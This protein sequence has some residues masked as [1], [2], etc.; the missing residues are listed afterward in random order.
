MEHFSDDLVDRLEDLPHNQS[1][2]RKYHC[3][4][5]IREW[6][7]A[8]TW[9]RGHVGQTYDE[10]LPKWI[11]LKWLPTE[12]RNAKGLE[13]TTTLTVRCSDGSIREA[14][15]PNSP[16]VRENSNNLFFH[17]ENHKLCRPLPRREAMAVWN[18]RAKKN[19]TMTY[20]EWWQNRRTYRVIGKS[21]R[22]LLED[23]IWYLLSYPPYDREG[24]AIDLREIQ[25]SDKKSD[26]DI[27]YV[28]KRQ[29]NSKE[30]KK[31]N[32]KNEVRVTGKRPDLVYQRLKSTAR[33]VSLT[34]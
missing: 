34:D 15:N 4:Y 29:L 13:R 17:P 3:G 26:W 16:D 20:F 6:K 27:A 23:G 28:S 1:I 24:K 25:W 9:L 7:R 33:V 30:L 5:W 14:T 2:K 10:I 8:K 22:L 31:Y 11:A 19:K 32:V 18:L 12:W 21:T